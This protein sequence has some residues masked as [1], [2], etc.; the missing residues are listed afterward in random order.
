MV[1]EARKS[2]IGSLYLFVV[3]LGADEW[4]RMSDRQKGPWKVL[5][6]EESKKYEMTKAKMHATKPKP[7][8][9]AAKAKTVSKTSAR[10]T[11]ASSKKPLNANGAIAKQNVR[12]AASIR[13]PPKTIRK[14]KVLLVF[15]DCLRCVYSTCL[16]IVMSQIRISIYG[17]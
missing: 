1:K 11:K 5:A 13:K 3:T 15:F 8:A 9:S 16:S 17:N 14:I 4:K 6:T 7:S 12:K 10:L 2:N